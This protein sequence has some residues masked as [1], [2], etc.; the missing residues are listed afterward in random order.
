[1]QIIL[2][3]ND[4]RNIDPKIVAMPIVPGLKNIPLDDL[5]QEDMVQLQAGMRHYGMAKIGMKKG[6]DKERIYYVHPH[7]AVIN[8][9]EKLFNLV[10]SSG[11]E[12]LVLFPPYNLRGS[13]NRA[14]IKKLWHM[15][16]NMLLDNLIVYLPGSYWQ[17]KN[18]SLVRKFRQYIKKEYDYWPEEPRYPLSPEEAELLEAACLEEEFLEKIA[19]EPMPLQAML[20]ADKRQKPQAAGICQSSLAFMKNLEDKA[21][22]YSLDEEDRLRRRLEALKGRRA[23]TFS[24]MLRRLIIEKGITKD[25]LVYTR[26]NMDRRLFS[27][28]CSNR[29]YNPD[30]KTVLALAIALRLNLDETLDLLGTAGYTLSPAIEFDRVMRGIIEENAY[31]YDIIDINITLHNMKLPQ[32]GVRGGAYA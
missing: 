30:K 22:V 2:T 3:N 18:P 15:A 7:E 21:D 28:I 16:D 13:D 20:K 27:K 12:A 24:M 23:E 5:R 11:Y 10:R 29:D 32:L 26:A 4:W 25:S 1:M 9:Y 17:L 14:L 6:P 8:F 31:D 19:S